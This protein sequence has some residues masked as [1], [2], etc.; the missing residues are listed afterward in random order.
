MSMTID[1]DN[2]SEYT[3]PHFYD[4]EN[5]WGPDDDFYLALAKRVGGP[6]LDLACGTGRLTRALA[7]TGLTVTG[8]DLSASMLARA[9]ALAGDLPITW[10]QGDCRELQLGQRFRLVLMTSHAFQHMLTSA[11]QDR[12][13]A[14]VYAHLEVGGIFAFESR[15]PNSAEWEDSDWVRWRAY[16]L[17]TART[18]GTAGGQQVEVWMAAIYDQPNAL[19][20]WHFRRIVKTGEQA[21]EPLESQITLLYTDVE[22]LNQRL[23]AHGFTVLEQ[24]GNWMRH[25]VDSDSPEIITICQRKI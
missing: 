11:D 12:L 3:N 20:H 18:N 17:P 19:E 10:H 24:Y 25:L 7:Q 14:T 9:R 15:H 23:V 5:R 16:T 4:A 1:H 13:L 8:V 22:P 21:A 2:L 6:V